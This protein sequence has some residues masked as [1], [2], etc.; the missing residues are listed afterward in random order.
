MLT[1][2][3]EAYKMADEITVVM[4]VTKPTGLTR[5]TNITHRSPRATFEMLRK[6]AL[7]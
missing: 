6:P 1:L 5:E 2:Q 7:A 3:E 4:L